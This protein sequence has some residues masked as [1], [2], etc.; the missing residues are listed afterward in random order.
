MFAAFLILM[1]GA[2]TPSPAT[3]IEPSPVRVEVRG[4][5]GDLRANVR[6]RLSIAA[7]AGEATL[8]EA[9]VRRLHA[10]AGDE[11]RIALQPFGFY[12]PVIEPH[13]VH[14]GRRWIARYH[15][16]PGEP[17][18]ITVVDVAIEGPGA[19]DPALL[20]IFPRSRVRPGEPLR[21]ARYDAAKQA[22]QNAAA[23]RGYFDAAVTRARVEVDTAAGEARVDVRM[24]TGPRHRFGAVRFPA[25]PFEDRL[26]E[27]FVTFRPGEAFRLD[28]LILL[29]RRLTS[30]DLF[31]GVEVEPLPEEGT[32]LEVPVEVR[33]RTRPRNRYGVGAGYG[34]DT[35]PRGTLS[36]GRRW[37]NASAH[38]LRF[39]IQVS[40]PL[41]A[42]AARYAAPI[43][44]RVGDE[45][46]LTVG[47][48]RERFEVLETRSATGL[49]A[50]SY[51]RGAWREMPSLRFTEE[52]DR[53][54]GVERQSTLLIPQ[55]VWSRLS[56]DD[57][58][59]PRKGSRVE[60]KVL[61][62]SRSIG[63]DVSMLQAGLRLRLQ[64]G[65]T[66]R[67]RA[68]LRF[69]AEGTV[70]DDIG[71]LPVSLRHFAGGGQSVRGYSFR[72]LAPRTPEGTLLGGRHLL[73]GSVEI[74]Q[75]VVGAFGIAAFA[76]AG[77]AFN[78]PGGDWLAVGAGPGLRWRSPV[79]PIRVDV[80]WPLDG[81]GGRPQVH[82]LVG[83][84]L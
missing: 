76:D 52:W 17:V 30:S 72:S 56:A 61:G 23:A 35:G 31:E 3:D 47:Y 62:T 34:T 50:A 18:R 81:S 41:Q 79:G 68:L 45:A 32:D 82:F 29:Q 38:S 44:S 21:H 51:A 33:L 4:I 60:L 73:A 20:R 13:L 6:L 42:A 84:G 70:V 64:Q 65:L 46:A 36:V 16:R 71:D 28:E 8:S 58:L 40:D 11:I 69:D 49:L 78:D 83:S 54:G 77:G 9:Q 55:A 12:R 22:L 63:S 25:T 39:E 7:R 43:G 10:R 74:E 80:A 59:Y 15:V 75:L 37:V 19:D 57:P 24:A 53:V 2:Q 1:L 27:R 48:R 14:D 26:L 5:R 67:G 66:P